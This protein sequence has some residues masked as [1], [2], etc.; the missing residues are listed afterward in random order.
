M[1]SL[2]FLRTAVGLIASITTLN[3][4]IAPT[5]MQE[6]DTVSAFESL[7]IT[8]VGYKTYNK[9]VL[10]PVHIITSQRMMY[11]LETSIR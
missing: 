3:N 6:A 10:K 9:K 8:G 7:V 5:S 2:L 11:L 1:C 4:L